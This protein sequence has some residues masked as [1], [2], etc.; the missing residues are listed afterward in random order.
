LYRLGDFEPIEPDL[1]GEPDL[2]GEPDLDGD[3][4]PLSAS[5]L[6]R[7]FSIV[8]IQ[9]LWVSLWRTIALANLFDNSL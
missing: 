1:V 4:F 6:R 5:R 2:R 9:E 8:F 3:S 7:N